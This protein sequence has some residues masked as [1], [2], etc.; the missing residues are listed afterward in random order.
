MHLSEL[1]TQHVSQLLEMA[2]SN[3]ID[4]ATACASRSLIFALLKEPRKERRIHLR[5]STLEVLPDAS[6]SALAD[7][8]YCSTD[9]IYVSPRRSGDSTCTRAIRSRAR[10]ARPKDGGALRSGQGRQGQRGRTRGLKHKILFEKLTPL[11]PDKTSS[12]SAT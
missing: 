12:S 10:S 7:T 9:D 11:H 4:G 8:S 5:R 1:K 2:T 6:A 3:E